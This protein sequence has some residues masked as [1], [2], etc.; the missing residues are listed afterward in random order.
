MSYFR[1]NGTEIYSDLIFS[2]QS[3]KIQNANLD[4]HLF[5]KNFF[6]TDEVVGLLI[7]MNKT[8]I[9]TIK[10][11]IIFTFE[12]IGPNGTYYITDKFLTVDFLR[13]SSKIKHGLRIDPSTMAQ[14]KWT[15]RILVN[16]VLN[17]ESVFFIQSMT[18]KKPYSLKMQ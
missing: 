9:D 15:V 16:N 2:V 3:F 4:S 6:V 12:W 13:S 11:S 14:G 10:E 7:D 8:I 5:T 1:S 17:H 18:Y